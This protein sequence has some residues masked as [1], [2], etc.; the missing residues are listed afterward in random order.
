VAIG[1]GLA[2]GADDDS[3]QARLAAQL[4]T[5]KHELAPGLALRIIGQRQEG[6]GRRTPGGYCK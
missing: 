5:V 1:D 3:Q 6:A 2:G 4:S